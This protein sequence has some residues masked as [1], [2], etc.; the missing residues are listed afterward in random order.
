[1]DPSW[2]FDFALVG[3]GIVGACLADELAGLGASVIVLDAGGE[4]GH[5]TT[6]AVGVTVPSLRYLTDPVFYRWLCTARN[7]LDEDVRRLAPEHGA[8]TVDKPV[9][10]VVR[11]TVVDAFDDLLSMWWRVEPDELG[12]A[13][14]G[15]KLPTGR[16]CLLNPAG[17]VV[18]GRAYLEAVRASCLARGVTWRQNTKVRRVTESVVMTESGVVCADRVVLTAGAWSSA[19]GLA[20][21][22]GV[23]PQRGQL[24]LLASLAK[25]PCIF[26]SSY[27]LAPGVDGRIV[28]GA[29]EE[30]VGFAD[31]VT[32]EGVARLMT[33]AGAAMPELSHAVPVEL[34]A[35]LRPVTRTGKPVT[36][37]VPGRS[38]VYVATGHAGHGLL[39]ARCTA[40]G[41]AAGLVH[42]D[43]EQ[44]ADAL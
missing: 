34:R 10:R 3:G 35:G 14:D 7:H 43:W 11:K 13:A 2:S 37:R 23:R 44:L 21:E 1:M 16:Q 17:L 30:E 20:E 38:R 9:L 41:M 24:L 12:P 22:V 29:T 5:A 26:S 27:Y 4:P 28:V 39:S 8:F 36:G 19:E 33:F 18:D 6:R 25:L 15:L 31:H 40:V 42:D 32:V